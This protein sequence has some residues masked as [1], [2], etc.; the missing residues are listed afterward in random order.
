MRLKQGGSHVKTPE[1]IHDLTAMQQQALRWRAAGHRIGFVPTMGNLHA[2]HL[3]LVEQAQHAADKV[4]V[5]IFVNPLQ[6]GPHE[7]Y[8]RYPRTLEADMAKLACLGVNVVFNPYAEQ[9]YPKA[10]ATRLL[11]DPALANLWEGAAR[12]GHFDGMVTVVNKLFNLVLPHLAVFGQKDYQQLRI[13]EEMVADLSVPVQIARAPIAREPDGLAM[14]SRNQ[15]LN[16]QQRTIAPHLYQI[17]LWAKDQLQA[18]RAPTEVCQQAEARLVEA[19]FD[20]VDYFTL[21]DQRTLQP[22]SDF[23][24]PAVLL[25]AARLG[26]TRLLDNLEVDD[27]SALKSP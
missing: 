26:S 27:N 13:I 6:F 7:D 24:Q 25:A 19:G 4:V 16:P 23:T 9:M 3:A 18:E 12:P 17:L 15:Y 8:D 5:S 1:L 10:K 20:A 11:A 21:V 14:S 2:G 22:H